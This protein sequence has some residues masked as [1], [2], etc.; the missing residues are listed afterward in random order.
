MND[1]ECSF[2]GA[3]IIHGKDGSNFLDQSVKIVRNTTI[4]SFLNVGLKLIYFQVPGLKR[5]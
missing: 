4:N 2:I 5:G 3:D 1:L